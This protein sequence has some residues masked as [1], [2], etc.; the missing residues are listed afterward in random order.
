M[1]YMMPGMMLMFFYNAPSGLSLYIMTSISGGIVES[2]F[3]RKH[4][5]E[6]EAAEEARTTVVR[7]GGKGFR[8]TREKK[9]KGPYKKF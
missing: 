1:K 3:I 2:I 9:P 6:K 5:A 7:V 4:I 8:E